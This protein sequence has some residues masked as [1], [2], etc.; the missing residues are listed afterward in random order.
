MLDLRGIGGGVISDRGDRQFFTWRVTGTE[1]VWR[2]DGPRAWPVQM[3]GG[4]DRTYVEELAPDDSFVVVSRDVGGAE[5]PGLYVLAPGGGPLR[6]VMHEPNVQTELAYITEDSKSL[7]FG[8]N[9][10][11]PAS[12]AIYRWD[13]VDGKRTLV[14]DTPGLWHVVD[15]IADRWLMTKDLGSTHVEVYEYDLGKRE[16]TPVLGVGETEDY[17]VA[18]GA[19]PGQILVRTNKLGELSQLYT[20][21]AGK[22]AP[23]GAALPHETEW[24][25]IDRSRTHVYASR[26]VDGYMRIDVYDA[27]TLRPVALPKLPAADNVRVAGI[28]RNGRFVQLTLDAAQMAPTTVTWDWKAKKLDTWRPPATPEFD[29]SHFAPVTLEYYPARDGTKIPMFVRRPAK[30]DGPCPVIVSVHGGPEG[31]AEP[32][33]EPIAQLYTEAGFVIVEPN[34]RGSTGYGKAWEH[35]D[36]GAKRLDVITD[37]EDL[38]RYVR[39]AWAKDGVAP[40]IGILG[41]SYGGYSTLMALT[42]FAGDFDAGVADHFVSNLRTFLLNTAPYRRILRISEYGDPVKDAAVLE[43]LS[44]ITYVAKLKAPLL[45][46]QGVNDPRTPVGEAL[47]LHDELAARNVPAQLILFPDEGHGSVKRSNIVL[48]IGHTIAF[49]ERYLR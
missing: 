47:Q 8:A 39:T 4:E 33:F 42:Y 13:V 44:P 49:F 31:Q 43:K 2:Q 45:L 29:V 9:D 15:H 10:R 18:F 16:L 28:S 46:F 23:V 3:T 38:S 5:N 14:F 41:G 40:K 6:V 37:L 1:Q 21:E 19:K 25:A 35:A 22:L 26:N 48:Q 32:G 36:D 20:L 27:K 17:Q 34:V 7:Y 12:Y 24:F 11:D 30:C